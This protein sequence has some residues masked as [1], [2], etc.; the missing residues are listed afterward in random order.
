MTNREWG[1]CAVVAGRRFAKDQALDRIAMIADQEDHRL[2]TIS[3]D[4][5]P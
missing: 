3:T 1:L 4:F 5:Q 2:Q